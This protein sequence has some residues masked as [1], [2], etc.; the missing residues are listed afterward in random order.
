M[1]SL[2]TLKLSVQ[3]LLSRHRGEYPGSGGIGNME[4]LH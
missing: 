2:A 1:R 3:Q 4:A